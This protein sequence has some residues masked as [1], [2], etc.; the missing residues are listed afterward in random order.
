M[1][2]TDN[3]ALR[4]V[5]SVTVSG[6]PDYICALLDFSSSIAASLGFSMEEQNHIR[7]ALDEVVGFLMRTALADHDDEP[8]SVAFEPQADGIVIRIT[9]QGAPLDIERMPTF[10][11][12]A[13]LEEDQTDALSLHLAKKVM[14][15]LDF[16]N[17]G[18][19]GFEIVLFK[20]SDRLHIKNRM[21]DT[22]PVCSEQPSGSVRF[23]IRKAQPADSLEIS[24]CAYLSYGHSY[25]DYIYY[26]ERIVEMNASGELRSMV[27]VTGEG[28]VVGHC[29]LKFTQGRA[30]RAE[31]GVLFTRPD[32]RKHGLGAALTTA[33]IDD[34]RTLGL[35]GLYCHAVTGHTVSQHLTEKNSFRDCAALLSLFPRE[36]D[37][38]S[39]AG[40]Q[41]KKMAGLL[42]WLGLQPPRVRHIDPPARYSAFVHELYERNGLPV[43]SSAPPRATGQPVFRVRRMPLFNVAFIEVESAGDD[44]A[45]LVQRICAHCRRLCREK[46]DMLYLYINL[47]EAG[48]AKVAEGC[49]SEGFIFAGI[50]P[51]HFPGGDGLVLQYYNLP[52]DPFTELSVATKTNEDLL[53]YIRRDFVEYDRIP[54]EDAL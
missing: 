23:D 34:A 20:Q 5:A 24:R 46:L 38:R 8:V 7:L 25:E 45:H 53:E 36:V 54:E 48:A 31:I 15:R 35:E 17:R 30:D 22:S 51:G 9:E 10:S 50:A 27:A 12:D 28:T 32:F 39:L 18:R 21:P 2:P 29:A 3:P 6:K 52:D 19:G 40:V 43:D 26:P 33:L 44:P 16:L 49:R 37:F 47:E 41:K 1:T 42:Q 4:P 13:I 14:D 11:P